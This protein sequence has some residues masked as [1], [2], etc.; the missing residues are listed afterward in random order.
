VP[1]EQLVPE[2]GPGTVDM[3]DV[4]PQPR[5]ALHPRGMR[6]ARPGVSGECRGNH[7]AIRA[8]AAPQR[9]RQDVRV[10]DR[11]ASA[12]REVLQHRVSGVTEQR[13]AAAGPVLH[14]RPVAHGP[15]AV[16]PQ[17]RQ[18]FPHAGAAD[19]ERGV[20]L[21][22]AAPVRLS[23]GEA[24]AAEDG[25]LVVQGAGAQRVLDEMQ[26]RADPRHHLVE[27]GMPGHLAHVDRAAVGDIS[28][29]DQRIVAEHLPDPGMQ[30][31][32]GDHRAAPV[33]G[34]VGTR[35]VH[36]VA[37]IGDRSDLGVRGQRYARRPARVD[38]DVQQVA[39]VQ[40]HIRRPVP[41]PER[42]ADVERGKLPAGH[43]A[44]ERQPPEQYARLDHPA[45]HAQPVQHAGR[46]RGHLQAGAELGEFV[47]AFQHMDA[48][49]G[50]CHGERGGKTPDAPA[51]DEYATAARAA[52]CRHR[53]LP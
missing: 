9:A 8:R 43:R 41:P 35:H 4:A 30:A 1:G 31:V 7:G 40:H 27:P 21:L 29:F 36:L 46:V 44:A 23:R 12:L 13:D 10:L 25:D 42:L 24:P 28:S 50:T 45:E 22:R 6:R 3:P 14:R 15:A 17:R 39:A 19:G 34:A 37:V 33:A 38:E 52:A 16:P 51:G 53:H 26:A 49:P 48:Q 18:G 47:R 5:C 2:H 11:L 32:G 20:Q